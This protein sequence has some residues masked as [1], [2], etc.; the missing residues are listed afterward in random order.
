M[1]PVE[2][3]EVG[4]PGRG[5]D[6]AR[7]P[8]GLADDRMARRRVIVRKHDA[9]VQRQGVGAGQPAGKVVERQRAVDAEVQVA[10]NRLVFPIR[11]VRLEDDAVGTGC[12]RQDLGIRRQ[13]RPGSV[14]DRHRDIALGQLRQ[15]GYLSGRLA[16]RPVLLVHGRF[17]GEVV[18]P[19]GVLVDQPELRQRLPGGGGG[20]FRPVR[21]Y[22]LGI[23]LRSGLAR[24][25]MPVHAQL[26][27][28]RADE[29]H[30]D[31]NRR[32]SLHVPRLDEERENVAV[33]VGERQVV[34]GK[35]RTFV[36]EAHQRPEGVRPD[37]RPVLGKRDLVGE[38]RQ[39][40]GVARSPGGHGYL[41]VIREGR[42]KTFHYLERHLLRLIKVVPVVGSTHAQIVH[43]R[44]RRLLEEPL[45]R[46]LG[47]G[48]FVDRLHPRRGNRAFRVRCLLLG[49]AV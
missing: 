40:G 25:E 41:H 32:R 8:V 22:R 46:V 44:L 28:L 12:R 4:D 27:R 35:P 2:V 18:D 11:R 23:V 49:R 21:P 13:H 3:V 34:A 45:G 14:D 20:L 6:L 5:L 38:V 9:P 47:I 26:L 19:D 7:P 33:V 10:D 15:N 17:A 16:R 24:A 36:E 48:V 37:I 39:L 30:L 43:A 31:I 42:A 1:R 29:R